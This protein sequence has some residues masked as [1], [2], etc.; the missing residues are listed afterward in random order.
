MYQVIILNFNHNGEW[1]IFVWPTNLS[2][3]DPRQVV[4][5]VSVVEKVSFS[6]TRCC[7]GCRLAA[8]IRERNQAAAMLAFQRS[9][10]EGKHT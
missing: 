7:P 4:K 10:R 3:S 5:Y 6:S 9:Q 2:T 8:H 1:L